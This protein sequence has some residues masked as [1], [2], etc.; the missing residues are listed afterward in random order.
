LYI[1]IIGIDGSGKSTLTAAL[2][3]LIAAELGVTVAAVGDGARCAAP[4]EHLLLPGFAPAGLPPAAR[5]GRLFGHVARAATGSRR[6]YPPLKLMQLALQERAVRRFDAVYHPDVILSD[7]NLLL[8]AAGRAVNYADPR[9]GLAGGLV[10]ALFDYVMDGAPLDP[11]VRRAVP[12]LALLRWLRRLDRWRDLGLTR[13]PDALILLDAEPATALARLASGG[14][15]LDRHENIDDLACA[16]A[17]YLT[18]AELFRRRCGGDRQLVIDVTRLSLGQA[19]RRAIDFVGA[20]TPMPPRTAPAALRLGTTAQ[21]LSRSAVV[22]RKVL[23]PQYMLRYLL[24]NL[25][26]GSAREL[27]FPL[28]RLGR[29]LLREGYS[30]DVM[31]AIYEQDRER[32]GPLDRAFLSYPLHRA[33][34]HRLGILRRVV[35]RELE[36]RLGAVDARGSVRVLTAPSG[37]A[38]DLFQPLERLAMS[39]WGLAVPLARTVGSSWE[40]ATP[41]HILASDLDPE[42]RI[43]VQLCRQ[44]HAAGVDFAFARGDLTSAELRARLAQSGPFDLVLFV[45]LSSWIAKPDLIRHLALVRERLLAPGGVLVADCFTPHAYA[46][47]GKYVG[48]RANYYSPREWTSILSYCGFDPAAMRWESGPE[49]INHVCVARV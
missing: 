22:A 12:G 14:K 33:V 45:G 7:G 5:L 1:S 18:V 9:A 6:L 38:Y 35:A 2:T 48:Y 4:E 40:Q 39:N 13:L 43:E 29:L 15:P 47:S 30:A 21:E 23:A 8:S 27:T 24:P 32:A 36:E 28:S 31:R 25:H 16:R 20:L 11:T 34:Y 49:R 17:M 42:R 37:Y 19:L 3:D 46:L 44:A 10:E 41:V 26:R